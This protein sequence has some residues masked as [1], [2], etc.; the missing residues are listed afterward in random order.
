MKADEERR[1]EVGIRRV[2]FVRQF[3]FLEMN[4]SAVQLHEAPKTL[5]T[6]THWT[7]T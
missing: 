2:V 1:G 3:Q 5:Q 6:S 4:F 7:R